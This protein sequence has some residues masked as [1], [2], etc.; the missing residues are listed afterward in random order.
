MRYTWRNDTDAVNQRKH[1]LPLSAGI[2]ALED[3]DRESW[4]DERMDYG[5]ERIIT[6]GRGHGGIL[7][8]VTVEPGEDHTHIISVRRAEKHEERWYHTGRP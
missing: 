2:A 8:V 4:I 3:P 6:L 1:R 5:E 7:F